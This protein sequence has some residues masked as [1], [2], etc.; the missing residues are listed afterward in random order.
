MFLGAPKEVQMMHKLYQEIG[1]GKSRHQGEK[2]IQIGGIK[3]AETEEKDIWRWPSK[4]E[5]P[6]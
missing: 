1:H 5:P 3:K 2:L 4:S 6:A